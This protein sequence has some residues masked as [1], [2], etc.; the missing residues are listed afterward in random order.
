MIVGVAMLWAG[1]RRVTALLGLVSAVA[2]AVFVISCLGATD[3]M[4]PMFRPGL[5]LYVTM[6]AGILLMPIGI[7]SAMVGGILVR[8]AHAAG[9]TAG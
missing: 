7:A 2:G 5:G 8:S 4:A 3:A 1:P 9:T 6:L